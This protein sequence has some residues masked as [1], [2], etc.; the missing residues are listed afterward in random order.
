MP[1]TTPD[2]SQRLDPAALPELMDEPCSYTQF[3]DCV[4]DIAVLTRLTG[5]Y[6]PSL[7]FLNQAVDSDRDVSS[8]K[9]EQKVPLHILDVGS[10][11][12]DVLRHIA[13]WAF[14]HRQPVELTGID[15]NPHATRAAQEL[16]TLHPRYP[17]I[18]F[19][20][21]DLFTHPAVQAPDLVLSSLVTH[22]MH[23]D[24][25]IRFLRWMEAHARHG[26]F[27]SDLVRSPRAY[28]LFR[29]LSRALRLHSFVQ[30]DG[31]VS[32][33]RAFRE[34]DWHQL[35][36]AADIPPNTVRIHRAAIGRLCLTRL[37]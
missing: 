30:N 4:R 12:G 23:D 10:G 26:W 36:S 6:T 37:R 34:P 3:R 1:S 35:L 11:G 5:A 33:R 19:L 20:T 17:P 15:L 28:A 13:R 27:I 14:R 31:L 24:E 18:Q 22:H 7:R 8:L 21:G 2:F 25:I 29:P 16:T 32:I 9:P